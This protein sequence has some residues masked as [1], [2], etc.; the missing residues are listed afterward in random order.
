LALVRGDVA[1]LTYRQG[2]YVLAQAAAAESAALAERIGNK[3]LLAVALKRLAL[4]RQAQ[5]D[6]SHALMLHRECLRLLQELG[7][8]R[9]EL[10]D[11]LGNLGETLHQLGDDARAARL[12]GA[13]A[14]LQEASGATVPPRE[15][16][17]PERTSAAVRRVLGDAAFAVAWRAGR[18][19]TMEQAIAEALAEAPADQS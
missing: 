14:M 5:G 1:A 4:A 7:R 19:L 12:L 2:N 3:S 9:M 17:E 16:V 6:Y 15:Q 13:A 8:G 10:A 18:A 11:A